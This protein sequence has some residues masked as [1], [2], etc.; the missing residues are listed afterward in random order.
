MHGEL[1]YILNDVINVS[2]I[3]IIQNKLDAFIECPEMLILPQVNLLQST[4]H[5]STVQKRAFNV[6]VAIYKQLYEK[7]HSGE[8][9][10]PDQLLS[11]TPEQVQNMLVG[12]Q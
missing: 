2:F 8:Y 1:K 10:N 5:C 4:N 12:R 11:K 7:I 3:F 9:Q 6:I